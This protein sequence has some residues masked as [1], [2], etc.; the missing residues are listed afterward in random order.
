[1]HGAIV[2]LRSSATNSLQGGGGKTMRERLAE[3]AEDQL[4]GVPA[5]GEDERQY[6]FL[7]EVL[8]TL[9]RM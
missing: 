9:G 3:S 5:G 1:M 8:F 4:G 7:R 2:L 6:L